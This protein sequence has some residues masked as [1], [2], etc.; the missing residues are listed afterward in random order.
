MKEFDVENWNRK[1][2]YNFFK[3]YEDPF[4]N[5]TSNLNVTNLYTYCKQ[6]KLSFSLACLYVALKTMNEIVE[7]KLRFKNNKVYLCDELH[8][9]STILNNDNTFSFC[10]FDNQPNLVAFIKNGKE[11]LK[12]HHNKTEKFEP[13]EEGLNLVHCTTLPWVSFTSF[14]HARNGDE[15]SKGIPKI[16]FGKLFD[17]NDLK[18]I[19]FSVEVHH[20]LIDGFQVGILYE[21]M[22]KFIDELV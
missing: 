10:Y 15:G 2:Q 21:E 13:K 17:E 18:K 22:Q 5:L 8:I 12:N 20:A 3:G 1:T 4:F 11:V 14:K 19:P 16:V 7:F 6:H 9:G